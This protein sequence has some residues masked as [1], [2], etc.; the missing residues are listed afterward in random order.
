M[1][2]NADIENGRAPVNLNVPSSTQSTAF[3]DQLFL[4]LKTFYQKERSSHVSFASD[5]KCLLDTVAPVSVHETS[6][7]S[8]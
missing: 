3:G 1:Y 5:M 4:E 6:A 8:V 2:R 7:Q